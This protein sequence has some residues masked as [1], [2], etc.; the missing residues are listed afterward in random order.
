MA[1]AAAAAPEEAELKVGDGTARAEDVRARTRPASGYRWR[2]AS[3]VGGRSELTGS[4]CRKAAESALPQEDAVCRARGC[5]GC[6][7][8]PGFLALGL[9]RPPGGEL[10]FG[11]WGCRALPGR[12]GEPQSWDP[13][14]VAVG[15]RS[16]WKR[17]HLVSGLQHFRCRSE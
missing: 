4:R 14:A 15:E 11:R 10:I 17:D 2:C 12:G 7:S 3:S 6:Q 5:R 9:G 13:H 1:G 8:A 16:L